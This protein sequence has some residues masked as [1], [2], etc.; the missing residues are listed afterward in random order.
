VTVRRVAAALCLLIAIA[1]ALPARA[2]ETTARHAILVDMKTGA[3]LFEKNADVLMPPASMSKIMTIYMVFERL[4]SGKLK[5]DDEFTV[6]ENAWRKGG[7]ASKG[8]TMFLPLDGRVKVEDLIRGIIVQSG[9]DASIVVAEGLAGSEE[10]FGEDMTRKA[11]SIGMPNTTWRNATGLPDPQHLTTARD[12]AQLAK[13]T[14]QDFPEYYHYYSEKEFVHHGIR[15]GNRNPLLY[16]S[17]GADG[18]KTGH[19]EASGYGLTASMARGDRRLILVVNGLPSMQARADETRRL[20]DFGF[21]EFENYALLKAGEQIGSA[22]VWLGAEKS[23]PLVAAD[24][25]IVTL[26]RASRPQMQAAL[27]YDAPVP[28]PIARNQPIAKL[29][30]NVAERVVLDAPLVAGAD[31]PRRGP[32]GRVVFAIGY[33]IGRLIG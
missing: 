9:N 7:A 22:E 28:A 24:D 6:T 33:Y 8:S 32:F 1:I 16:G 21:R 27:V 18:L 30:V 15:Q 26:P 10:A 4:K 2:F 17:E 25:V 11:R 29:R 20:F 23:V 13:R 12:L 14:I 19:T 5:L 3:V 31:V